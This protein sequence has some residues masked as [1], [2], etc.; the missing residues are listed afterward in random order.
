MVCFRWISPQRLPAEFDLRERGWRLALDGEPDAARCVRLIDALSVDPFDLLPPAQPSCSLALGIA[1]SR[2]RALW[3]SRG[4]G[5]ALAWETGLDEIAARAARLVLPNWE[6]VR[7]H[8]SLQLDPVTRDVTVEGQRL[9]LFPRE[10]ALL[11]RLSEEP[12]VAVPRAELMHDVFGLTIEPG[13]NTL[14]VH[15]CR[16][17]KKLHAARL[18]H[19]LVTSSRDGGYSLVPE[20]QPQS[21]FGWRNGLDDASDSSEEMILLEEAAE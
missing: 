6:R 16:L 9:R 21:G 10:F 12:G 11:W 15:I 19:L 3:L 7:S 14:A 5:D 13:T 18:S 4:F 17:R 8:G 2:E 1:D 20:S